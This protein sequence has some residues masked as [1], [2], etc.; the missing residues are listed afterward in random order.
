M[1]DERVVKT[2]HDVI[3]ELHQFFFRQ[4]QRFQQFLEHYL[5]DIFLQHLVLAGI[6]HDIHS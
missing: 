5:V 6:P 3:A 4:I 2:F 1:V